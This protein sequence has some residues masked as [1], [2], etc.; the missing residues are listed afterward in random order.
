MSLKLSAHGV[1]VSGAVFHAVGEPTQQPQDGAAP[2][3]AP[4]SLPLPVANGAVD[5]SQLGPRG[6]EPQLELALSGP[7]GHGTATVPLS[8]PPGDRSRGWAQL[9]CSAPNVLAYVL[10]GEREDTAVLIAYPGPQDFMGALPDEWSFG[11]VTMC[12]THE[13]SAQTGMFISKCQ[14]RDI[15]TQLAEG[16]RV[17]DVRM[18]LNANTGELETYH[19]IRPQYSTLKVYLDAI[20]AFLA[21]H[22]R[23][24]IMIS[25]KEETPP[26]HPD[27]SKAVYDLLQ[28]YGPRFVYTEHVATLGELRG[29][30]Q[31][32]TRFGR[33][34]NAPWAE[35]LGFHPSRWPDSARDGFE[36]DCHGT[37][38][39]ISDWYGLDSALDIPLK[40]QAVCEF[41]AH[42]TA[43]APGSQI[44]LAFTSAARFPTAT[45]QWVA[46]GVGAPTFGL[47]IHGV[48]ARVVHWL[49]QQA[50]MGK[51]PRAIVM[52]DFYEY[53]GSGEAGLGSLLGA[54][55]YVK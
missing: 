42:T 15:A 41:L 29:K 19:G 3:P 28:T 7:A 46:K 53:T 52:A 24:A 40:A 32:M 25:L 18:R 45:P 27:F 22:P 31:L 6:G 2:A 49:L 21:A 11:D 17:L 14:D 44:S 51:R 20:D 5:L 35:G 33:K 50:V 8:A 9:V 54:M 4:S 48:N 39:R 38:I 34:D 36:C 37:P 26:D 23:E 30:A 10:F 1:T 13:S 47:G 55:N 43:C 12:G 16:V